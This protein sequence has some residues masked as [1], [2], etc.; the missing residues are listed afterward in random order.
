L[1]VV[2]LDEQRFVSALGA[3]AAKTESVRSLS[4][5]AV[6]AFRANHDIAAQRRAIASMIRDLSF[7]RS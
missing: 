1:L 6:S 2:R 7:V 3:I 5:R 4:A